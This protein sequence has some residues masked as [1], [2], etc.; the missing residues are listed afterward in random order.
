MKNI[1]EVKVVCYGTQHIFKDKYEAIRFFAECVANSEGAEQARYYYIL[2]EITHG[3]KNIND[4][5][6]F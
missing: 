2:Y 3:A 4:E 6:M 1:N 5:E